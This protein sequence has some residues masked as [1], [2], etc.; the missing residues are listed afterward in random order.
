M[1]SL[2]GDSRGWKLAL[3][4]ALLDIVVDTMSGATLSSTG[5]VT[6]ADLV[7]VTCA[8]KAPLTHEAGVLRVKM[9]PD[10]RDIIW[11]N[12]NINQTWRAGREWTANLFLFVGAI[13][14]S[15]PVAFVQALANLKSLGAYVAICVSVSVAIPNLLARR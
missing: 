9:A 3:T 10:P 6:F 12:A 8:V 15:V 7:A 2:A 13:L 1:R 5:F 11:T 14:W 4:S